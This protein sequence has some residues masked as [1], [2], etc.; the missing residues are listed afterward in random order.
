MK[1]ETLRSIFS[2]I[3]KESTCKRRKV[4]AVIDNGH[5]RV[6]EF[7]GPPSGLSCDTCIRQDRDIPSGTQGEICKAI[8]AEQ[9]AIMRGLSLAMDFSR[10]TIYVTHKPCSMC[11]RMIIAVGIPEVVYFNDYPDDFSEELLREAGVNVRKME[12]S[13]GTS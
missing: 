3:D 13:L 2:T 5:M 6:I 7:N 4:G 12:T 10:S 8:H 11:A 1:I 9:R